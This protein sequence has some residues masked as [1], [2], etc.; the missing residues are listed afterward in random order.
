MRKTFAYLSAA[1]GW[2]SGP[3][4]LGGVVILMRLLLP[5]PADG[6]AANGS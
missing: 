3:A 2:E 5:A 6:G 4:Y 1:L